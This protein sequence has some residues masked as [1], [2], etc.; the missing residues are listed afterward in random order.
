MKRWIH[1]SSSQS[2][3]FSKR[4]FE[5]HRPISD[6]WFEWALDWRDE[7]ELEGM[8]DS[9]LEGLVKESLEDNGYD[10]FDTLKEAC[11]CIFHNCDGDIDECLSSIDRDF[12]NS[13]GVIPLCDEGSWRDQQDVFLEYCKLY[14]PEVKVNLEDEG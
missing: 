12:G 10:V 6:R 13:V 2:S 5:E 8:D 11:D 1:A 14:H 7:E 3:K 4:Y 9:E